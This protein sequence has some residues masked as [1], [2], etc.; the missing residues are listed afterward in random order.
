MYFVCLKIKNLIN[1]LWYNKIIIKYNK[2]NMDIKRL[3]LDQLPEGTID[4]LAKKVGID[5]ATIDKIMEAGIPEVVK[6]GS[7]TEGGLFDNLEETVVSKSVSLKTGL[8][9]STVTKVISV[10]LPFI[11]ERVDGEELMKI[12]EGFS[13]GFGM[14]DVENIAEVILGEDN[15][16]ETKTE[17][18]LGGFLKNILGGFFGKK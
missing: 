9:E 2:I 5:G 4:M 3:I 8:D 1:K 6:Q 17:E 10:A 12:I 13:D 14:D 7:K 16:R 11:K 15:K 18:K